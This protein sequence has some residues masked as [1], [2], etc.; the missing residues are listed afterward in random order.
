MKVFFL[1]FLL[2]TQLVTIIS[3]YVVYTIQLFFW[4]TLTRTLPHFSY[5][6]ERGTRQFKSQ[7]CENEQRKIHGGQD[8]HF[9]LSTRVVFFFG[10]KLIFSSHCPFT[11]TYV[12]VLVHI[13]FIFLKLTVRTQELRH[14]TPTRN[15]AGPYCFRILFS[16]RFCSI[17]WIISF[18]INHSQHSLKNGIHV[19][20]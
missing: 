16:F 12:Y 8:I 2:Q 5:F 11:F 10:G 7:I 14:K 13:I 9:G 19:F 1:E 17:P 3:K 15:F 20:F 6:L 4:L 18:H